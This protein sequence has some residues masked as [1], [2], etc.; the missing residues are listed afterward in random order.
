M[1]RLNFRRIPCR[2][3]HPRECSCASRFSP[4]NLPGAAACSSNKW[5]LPGR[6]L[7]N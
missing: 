1:S 7:A 2:Q 5:L 4:Q 3:V 6:G